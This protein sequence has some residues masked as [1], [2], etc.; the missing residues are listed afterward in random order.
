MLTESVKRSQGVLKWNDIAIEIFI[1]SDRRFFRLGKQCRER[2]LNHL[3]HSISHERW[4]QQ[5]DQILIRHVVC[6]G[7]KWSKIMKVLGNHRTEH[8]IKNRF[9]SLVLKHKKAHPY[10][11]DEE[12]AVKG[13]AT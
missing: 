5:E 7:K 8:M 6:C 1:K 4:T 12:D 3:D 2:W 11:Y 10:V 13:I 9:I